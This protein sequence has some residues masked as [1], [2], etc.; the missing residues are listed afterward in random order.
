MI[1]RQAN[2]KVGWFVT[3]FGRGDD[4]NSLASLA[5]LDPPREPVELKALDELE[6][7]REVLKALLKA[8][9]SAVE[10]PQPGVDQEFE[11]QLADEKWAGDP[12]YLMMAAL[13]ASKKGVRAGLSLSRAD[14]AQSMA[15]RELDRIGRIGASRKIDE[16]HEQ[17]GALVRHMAVMATLTQGLSTDELVRQVARKERKA[18]ELRGKPRSDDPGIAGRAPANRSG[19]RRCAHYP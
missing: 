18:L 1:E 10:A 7:R 19:R 6:F 5:L 11:R 16:G 4:D 13:E 15:H 14:L 12:L 2:T 8:A 17:I 3:V 9:N